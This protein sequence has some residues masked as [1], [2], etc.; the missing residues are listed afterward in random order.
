MASGGW[1]RAVENSGELALRVG[2]QGIGEPEVVGR[3]Q[4]IHCGGHTFGRLGGHPVEAGGAGGRAA[5]GAKTGC[6]M[7]LILLVTY[8]RADR[9]GCPGARAAGRGNA[10]SL[11]CCGV[12]CGLGLDLRRPDIRACPLCSR[13]PVSAAARSALARNP[14]ASG[15]TLRRA[16]KQALMIFRRPP[17]LVCGRRIADTLRAVADAG[18]RPSRAPAPAVAARTP[19]CRWICPPWAPGPAVADLVQE[20]APSECTSRVPIVYLSYG[21]AHHAEPSCSSRPP[22]RTSRRRTSQPDRAAVAQDSD[23]AY[24]YGHEDDELGG[25]QDTVFRSGGRSGSDS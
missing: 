10:A 9:A 7:K 6:T 23:L 17:V 14:S 5:S 12:R 25:R 1:A 22:G 18:L 15:D 19:G 11:G 20:L 8:G 4:R 13:S 2:S 24:N 16:G 21:G 3:P